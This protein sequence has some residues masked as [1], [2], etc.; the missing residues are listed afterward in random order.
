MDESVGKPKE[1]LKDT[2]IPE[3]NVFKETESAP[4]EKSDFNRSS[5]YVLSKTVI[6]LVV[7]SP[8]IYPCEKSFFNAYTSIGN[9]FDS[10]F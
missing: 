6:Q 1:D 5:S 7:F 3:E 4:Q 9:A 8:N 10:A 2:A